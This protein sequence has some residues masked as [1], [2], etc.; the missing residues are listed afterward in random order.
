MEL[1]ELLNRCRGG[2]ELAWEALVRRYQARVYGLAVH[3]VRNA[4]EA[5]DVAQEIFVRIYRK[6]GSYR[7]EDAFLPWMLRVGRNVCI[8][9]LRRE[10]VRPSGAGVPI[11]N[12]PEIADGGPT[13]EDHWAADDRRQVVHRALRRLS[14]P[15]REMILLKEIQGLNLQEIAD[16]LGVPLGTVKSRSSRARIELARKVV[17]L[18]PSYGTP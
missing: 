5:R 3:Y 16:L 10:K 13:P 2:D 14:E 8:D 11:E 7:D 4:E 15:S 1:S 9:H 12:A 6:L 17:E 18:D